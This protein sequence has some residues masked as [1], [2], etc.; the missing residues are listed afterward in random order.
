M[1]NREGITYLQLIGMFPDEATTE[2]WF[3]EVRWPNGIA[4][5]FC[6]SL[7]ITERKNRK[8]Q[9]YHCRD[10]RKYFSVKTKTLM[11]S[12]PLPFRTWIIAEYLLST[13]LKGVSAHKLARDLGVTLKTAW[14][15]AHRIRETWED[16]GGLFQ[17]PVECD[18]TYIGGKEKNKHSHKKL[19]AGRGGVRKTPVV[20][21]KDRA[22][23][24]VRAV[25]AKG[26]TQEVLHR[27]VRDHAK[28]GAH[29]Y[30]D[31]HSGYQGLRAAFNHCSVNHSARQ[32][33]S[34]QAH[35]NGIE[36]FWAMLKRGYQGTY[37]SMSDKHL[38]RYVNEFAG[39]HNF[40]SLD[41]IDQMT[42]MVR[43]MD[44]KRLRYRDLV[45]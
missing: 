27:F 21:I 35:T 31:D 9:P 20:G 26:T 7:S 42:A 11:H 1:P 10:C 29:V 17:G 5:P 25:V 8:P 39:R 41:T 40:R 22:T 33:V 36:S 23:N 16:G 38:H 3:T 30:T 4:C 43:G 24:K 14:H 12:S 34:G 37:H 44:G 6:G 32:Y 2:A 15:V 45:G 28:K 19:R 13:N 18:E